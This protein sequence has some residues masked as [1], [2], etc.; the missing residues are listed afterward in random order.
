MEETTPTT[1]DIPPTESIPVEPPP[2]SPF[3]YPDNLPPVLD[4][5]GD[6][7]PP[8]KLPELK[9][10]EIVKEELPVVATPDA[11]APTKIFLMGIASFREF[12]RTETVSEHP[13]K[14]VAAHIKHVVDALDALA[15]TVKA[16][17]V[18]R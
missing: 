3:Q 8:E 16:V 18:K 12:L 17:G 15:K 2:P 4:K 6:E 9:P 14:L 5:F 11:A 13:G 1:P 10:A 7:I